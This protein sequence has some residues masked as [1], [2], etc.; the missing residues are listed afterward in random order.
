MKKKIKD[1]YYNIVW[2]VEDFL[3][4][5]SDKVNYHRRWLDNDLDK[6]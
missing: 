6:K 5:L 1:I 4:Y 2:K 3:C